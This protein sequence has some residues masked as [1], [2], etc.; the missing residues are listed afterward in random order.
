M[1]LTASR[2]VTLT[3]ITAAAPFAVRG[4]TLPATLAAGGTLAVPVSFTPSSWGQASG[5]LT[6]ATADGETVQLGG[7]VWDAPG[8][9]RRR[10]RCPSPTCP[11]AARTPRW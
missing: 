7:A 10:S 6:V 3:A 11:P 5:N 4:T 8:L 2:A 9:V 1:T